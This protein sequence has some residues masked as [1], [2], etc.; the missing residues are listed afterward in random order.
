MEE[1]NSLT[2]TITIFFDE[3]TQITSLKLLNQT[4]FISPEWSNS[5]VEM[6]VLNKFNTEVINIH[7]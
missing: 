6:L 3:L 4:N 1:L 2:K 7:I 5:P